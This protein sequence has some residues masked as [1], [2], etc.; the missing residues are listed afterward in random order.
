MLCDGSRFLRVKSLTTCRDRVFLTTP[1]HVPNCQPKRCCLLC[2]CGG[3][4]CAAGWGHEREAPPLAG[5]ASLQG[6][7]FPRATD[8]VPPFGVRLAARPSLNPPSVY[9]AEATDDQTRGFPN[10]TSRALC[11]EPHCTE[12][13]SFKSQGMRKGPCGTYPGEGQARALGRSHRGIQ[14]GAITEGGQPSGPSGPCPGHHDHFNSQARQKQVCPPQ[15]FQTVGCCGEVQSPALHCAISPKVTSSSTAPA[16][17][18]SVLG[19]CG[20]SNVFHR[21]F[22]PFG[23]SSLAVPF[24]LRAMGW[25]QTLRRVAFVLVPWRSS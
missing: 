4:G 9:T 25:G 10:R 23:T 21:R 17:A 18:A 15:N 19:V 16:G 20:T 13:L 12:P 8:A 22:H 14:P 11:A 1:L 2:D 7:G 3:P 5:D 24:T 6:Q